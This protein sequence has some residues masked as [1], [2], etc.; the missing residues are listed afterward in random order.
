MLTGWDR[1]Y[2]P[3]VIRSRCCGDPGLVAKLNKKMYELFY[4]CKLFDCPLSFSQKD[5]QIKQEKLRRKEVEVKCYVSG[6]L[7]YFIACFI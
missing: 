7:S 1:Y 3:A 5:E 4:F 6:L 2:G